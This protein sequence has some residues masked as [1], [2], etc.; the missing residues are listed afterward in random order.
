MSST[1]PEDRS[2][3]IRL[4]RPYRGR[5]AVLSGMSIVGGLAE[6]LFLVI[7]TRTALAVANG[8]A[9]AGIVAAWYVPVRVA[10]GLS[11]AVLV[12]RLVLSLIGVA[13]STRLSADVL[14]D[15]RKDLVAA[16]VGS[17]WSTKQAERSGSLQQLVGGFVG[18]ALGLV[19]AVAGVMGT[20]LNLFALIVVSLVID[21]LATAGVAVALVVFGSLMG[22]I[23]RRIRYRSKLATDAGMAFSQSVAEFSG[24]G[25]E[26]ETYGVG[27][28]LAGRIGTLSQRETIARA[29][30]D[31]LRGALGPFYSTLAYGALVVGLGVAAF[32]GTGELSSIG[33]VML[34]MLRSLSYGQQVQV[35]WGGFAA[36]APILERM[37]EARERFVASQMSSGVVALKGIR[38]IEARHVSFDYVPGRPVLKDVSFEITAGEVVGVI[39][40][41]GAGKSTLV[42]LLLGVRVPTSGEV[43]VNGIDLREIRRED[44]SRLSAFVA[45]DA[46]LISG[47]ASDNVRF[48][49]DGIDNDS[50]IG[51]LRRANIAEEVLALPDGCDTDLGVRG[52]RL[53]GGQRQR[54]SIARALV[55]NPRL[56]VL[57]EPTS[58]LDPVS[59]GL[60]RETIS[61]LR[62]S[63]TTTVI[64][65]HRMS[66]LDIC[67]RIMVVEDGRIG[68]FAAPSEL[69][70][71]SE[72]YRNALS[73]AGIV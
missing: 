41:S 1:T 15:L 63:E 18:G 68:S 27:D 50:I 11:L 65:A 40:S 33:A 8:K 38:S 37:Y 31:S 58:A 32:A 51:A 59:E 3:I 49:R 5:L 4:L 28:Q 66:T 73:S 25:L 35:A 62:G 10:V 9:S 47:S 48:F 12:V 20:G 39:G 6:A 61:A 55:G 30:A 23:R 43:L 7:V 56:L 72:F 42:Q 22:P 53:S 24:L 60:I 29:R 13:A 54:L 21:P 64:I 2:R 44:W 69:R 36:N 16:Y 70:L 34:V 45:Q 71:T 52:S 14:T 67:D 26:M 19:T 46:N 17:A 57:D